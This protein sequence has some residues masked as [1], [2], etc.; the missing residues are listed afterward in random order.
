MML[1]SVRPAP[2][3]V[4]LSS[5]VPREVRLANRLPHGG[6]DYAARAS[7][8]AEQIGLGHKAVEQ[9]RTKRAKT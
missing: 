1:R 9:P 2:A 8:F 5:G 3:T 6:A 7:E 4:T